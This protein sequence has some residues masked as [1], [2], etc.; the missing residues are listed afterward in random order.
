VAENRIDI[1]ANPRMSLIQSPL[2]FVEESCRILR[3]TLE[4]TQ[5]RERRLLFISYIVHCSVHV[6]A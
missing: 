5:L 1:R 3:G 6:Q 4:H 2:Q